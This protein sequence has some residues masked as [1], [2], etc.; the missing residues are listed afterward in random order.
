[1]FVKI[2]GIKDLQT[3]EAV[4]RLGGD[5][6]GFVAHKNSKRYISPDEAEK[7]VSAVKG[8]ILTAAV[9]V[10]SNECAD[11]G[12]CDYVQAED[13][14]TSDNCILSGHTEPAGVFRYFLYDKSRGSGERAQYPAWVDGY[15][16]RLILAGGLNPDNVAEIVMTYKPF[17][18]DVSSGVE[19]DGKKDLDKIERFIKEAKSYEK[20]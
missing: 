1:M 14:N 8:R 6:I 2:C 17:G 13:A 5:C 3:A 18:V 11:Y 4:I 10:T 16:D 12:F 9:G 7:I 20:R 19:T 15:K